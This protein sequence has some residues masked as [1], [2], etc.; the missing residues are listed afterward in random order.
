MVT[1]KRHMTVLIHIIVVACIIGFV[2]WMVQQFLP[3]DNKFKNVAYGLACL[4]FL[5]Y[6][7][8]ALGIFSI[9]DMPHVK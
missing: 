1:G 4:L 8:N 5:L 6:V 7:L 9:G 2:I 3:A